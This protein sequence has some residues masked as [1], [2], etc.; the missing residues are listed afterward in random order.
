MGKN[1]DAL[2]PCVL[3]FLSIGMHTLSRTTAH[4]ACPCENRDCEIGKNVS[5]SIQLGVRAGIGDVP[6]IL[7][8]VESENTLKHIARISEAQF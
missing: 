8:A 5:L 2:S 3:Q 1:V 6:D 7:A 4:G